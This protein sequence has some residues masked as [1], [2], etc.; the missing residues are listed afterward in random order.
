MS[1]NAFQNGPCTVS[2]YQF[3]TQLWTGSLSLGGNSGDFS[4]G[5]VGTAFVSITAEGE[6]Q[7]IW[8]S[9]GTPPVPYRVVVTPTYSLS[10]LVQ[11]IEGITITLGFPGIEGQPSE[12]DFGPAYAATSDTNG[13]QIQGSASSWAADPNVFTDGSGSYWELYTGF[14]S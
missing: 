12:G 2:V 6:V 4:D 10:G 9:D 11:T 7:L 14:A 13:V 8:N 5:S 3:G 1:T